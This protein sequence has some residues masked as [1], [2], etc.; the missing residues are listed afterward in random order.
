MKTKNE[1]HEEIIERFEE[2]I[3]DEIQSGSAIDLFSS[4]MAEEFAELYQEIENN[5]TPHVWTYLEGEYIDKAATGLNLPREVDESDDTYKY[6]FSKW[7]LSNEASNLTAIQ[8]KL[9]N[10]IYAS[11]AEYIP[12]TRGVGTATVYVIPKHYTKDYIENSLAEA[13]EKISS[14]VTPGLY[15][16][17]LTPEVKAVR[18]QISMSASNADISLLKTNLENEIME[19]IN[20]IA[21]NS[22]LEVGTINR[23]GINTQGVN[24]FNVVGVYIND[25]ITSDTSILQNLETKLLFDEIVW[26][27]ED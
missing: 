5:K 27:I 15:I 23:M 18:L 13:K 17:Y 22:F 10:M 24:Y 20:A 11:Y 19:Y 3:Q 4:A 21:P 1:V 7:V 9:L 16:E 6:R 8:T 26:I 12:R 2:K 25:E 14:V